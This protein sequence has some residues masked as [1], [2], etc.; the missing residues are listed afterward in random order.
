M[1]VLL[2]FSFLKTLCRMI[3][4]YKYSLTDLASGRVDTEP[5]Q[6]Y[7]LGE[8]L[9]KIDDIKRQNDDVPGEQPIRWKPIWSTC[10]W[11]CAHVP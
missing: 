2:V 5:S 3:G 1:R 7:L 4:Y 9:I 10:R 11:L 6:R 8:S